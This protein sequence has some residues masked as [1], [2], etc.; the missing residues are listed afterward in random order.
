MIFYK[1]DHVV[2]ETLKQNRTAEQ[3]FLKEFTG[4]R[5]SA[6]EARYLYERIKDHKWYVSEKLGRDVG[7]KV[8]AIDYLEN[9]YQARGISDS[10][11][12]RRIFGKRRKL[13]LRERAGLVLLT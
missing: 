3:I 13:N 10:D 7:L 1:L 4:A 8:A 12:S 11:Q 2:E 5:L 6:D 9:I